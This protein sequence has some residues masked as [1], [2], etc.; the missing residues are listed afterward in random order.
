MVF[1]AVDYISPDMETK[2]PTLNPE[3]W[4]LH[5]YLRQVI[6]TFF[7]ILLLLSCFFFV[8]IAFDRLDAISSPLNRRFDLRKAK[9]FSVVALLFTFLLV[10]IMSKNDFN[11]SR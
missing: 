5:H 9:N 6:T 4:S 1:T 3:C 10:T 2:I 8:A 7:N 11:N